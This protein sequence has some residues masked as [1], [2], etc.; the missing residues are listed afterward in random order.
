MSLSKIPPYYSEIN[1]A[2]K[3]C[4]ADAVVLEE[5]DKLR[6]SIELPSNYKKDFVEISKGRSNVTDFLEMMATEIKWG[7]MDIAGT[8]EREICEALRK[9]FLKV[10]IKPDKE[11]KIEKE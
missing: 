1:D 7:H 10:L 4:F 2:L 5:G 3:E 11:K 9:A 6:V 8:Y